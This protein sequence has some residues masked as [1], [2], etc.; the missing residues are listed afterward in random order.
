MT[1][2]RAM[3]EYAAIAI[4]PSN[5][6]ASFMVVKIAV[7]PSAPP[8]MPREAACCGVKPIAR[9]Q[10]STAKIPNCA[11][12]P[13]IDRRRLRNIGPK[14]VSA[15]TPINIIGGMKPVLMHI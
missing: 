2:T 11:P 1:G 14:S 15:P 12:A 3:Y 6:G 5:S 4:G 7:G 8:M 9:E 10:S 13:K